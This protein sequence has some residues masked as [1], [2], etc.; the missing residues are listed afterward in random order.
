MARY[1]RTPQAAEFIGLAAQTL[2][3]WRV[4]GSPIPFSRLGRAIVY[5][6]HDL[7]AF[8]ASRR[9]GAPTDAEPTSPSSGR[10][11]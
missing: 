4:E 6:V 11:A 5:D 7:E 1:V 2:N 3:K 10:A 8:V 9:E